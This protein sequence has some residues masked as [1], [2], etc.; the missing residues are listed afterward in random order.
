MTKLKV[1]GNELD[2]NFTTNSSSRYATLFRNKVIFC[3]R[4]IGVNQ[5]YIKLKEEV[6]PMKKAGAEVHFY[7]NGYNC[8]YSYNRQVRY[9]DNLQ[10]I[11]KLIEVEAEKLVSGKRSFED[12]L[13]DYREDEDLVKKRKEARETLKLHESE[14]NL[15]VIDKQFKIMARESHPDMETGNTE[16]FKLINEAHKILRKELE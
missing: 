13:T 2:V 12:F 3:L 6:F 10:V 7:L 11:S 4:K 1:K 15:E 5:D 8:Y 9:V 16:K 14:I